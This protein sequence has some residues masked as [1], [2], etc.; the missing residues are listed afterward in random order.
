MRKGIGGYSAIVGLVVLLCVSLSALSAHAYVYGLVGPGASYPAD[1][2]ITYIAYLKKGGETD[3]EILTEDG[4]NQGL[5]LNQGYNSEFF[6]LDWTSFTNPAIQNNDSLVFLFTG[7]G[8]EAGN[9]GTL[10]DIVNTGVGAQDFGNSTW[11][12]SVNPGIPTSLNA[13]GVSP[14]VVNLTWTGAKNG[15]YR[16]YRSSQ[17]SGAGNGASNGR[18]ARIAVDVAVTN[19]QDSS[20]P[21]DTCWYIVVADDSGNYSGHSDETGIDAALPVRL[22]TF[23]AR[24]DE[25]KVILEW[26]TESEWDNLGFHIYRQNETK[27]EFEKL[28]Q[29]LIPGAG[30][31]SDLRTYTWEDA[32]VQTGTTYWYQ[33][34]SMDYDGGSR[35]YGP[36][37]ASPMETLPVSFRLSQNYPNPFNPETWIDYQLP[38]DARVNLKVYNVRGQLVHT[39]VDAA[40]PAGAYRALWTGRDLDGQT[41]ASGVYFCR[42]EADT[43]T[44]TVKMIL[45]K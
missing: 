6:W 17:G 45:L 16:V 28:T 31:S 29:D 32:R 23:T 8:A 13:T 1:G 43:F 15:T 40:L 10:L 34:E 35:T 11:S 4:Y 39:L 37:S 3:N 9:A 19:Y 30:N 36:V 26:T 2:T 5:G 24:G 7:I 27:S 22:A 18:Y 38:H 33:L 21:T 42:M 44:E 25:G 12:A 41:A 14:G 20:A